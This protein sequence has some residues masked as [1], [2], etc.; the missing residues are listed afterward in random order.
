M[1][2]QRFT[3]D[4]KFAPSYSCLSHFSTKLEVSTTFLFLE[5]GIRGTDGR[6]DGRGATC[7]A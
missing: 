6:T 1:R 3:I 5:I 4:L 7:N 2:E